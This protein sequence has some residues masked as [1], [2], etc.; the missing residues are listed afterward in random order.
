MSRIGGGLRPPYLA[1][2]VLH[3]WDALDDGVLHLD[4]P[5]RLVDGDIR[6]GNRHVKEGPLVELGSWTAYLEMR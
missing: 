2:H 6:E 5:L 4:Q 1:E 3:L